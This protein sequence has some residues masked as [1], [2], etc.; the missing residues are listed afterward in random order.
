MLILQSDRPGPSCREMIHSVEIP[1]EQ[2]KSREKNLTIHA[3][4]GFCSEIE[5]SWE[6]HKFCSFFFSVTLDLKMQKG[7][8]ILNPTA[9]N[10]VRKCI[11]NHGSKD[12]SSPADKACSLVNPIWFTHILWKVMACSFLLWTCYLKMFVIHKGKIETF[13]FSLIPESTKCKCA[14]AQLCQPHVKS[15]P[16]IYHL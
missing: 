2:N 9:W 15:F 5:S 13:L 6:W 4:N 12:D 3:S 10:V 14:S 1:T 7:S 16:T 11:W 8:C